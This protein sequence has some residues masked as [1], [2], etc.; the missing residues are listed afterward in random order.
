M[1]KLT[2]AGVAIAALLTAH[3]ANQR[4][5]AM[6]QERSGDH[7]LYLP[8]GRLL[9]VASLGYHAP[10]ADLIFLWS[11]QYY[12]HYHGSVRYDY[13][14]QIYE[15]VI[16]VLDPRFRD[17]YLLG[18][19]ILTL[20]ARRPEDGLALLDRGIEN[21]PDD[22]VLPFE[23]GFTA[24][25]SLKDYDR[26][27]AYFSRAVEIP[28]VHPVVRR[29]HA[30]MYQRMGDP[31]ASLTLWSD[32]LQS[33]G[34]D[35]VRNVAERHVKELVIEIHV[36]DLQTGVDLFRSR[37]GE[38]PPDLRTLVRAGILL[39]VPLDLDGRTYGYDPATGEVSSPEEG[40]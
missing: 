4:L 28:G 35:Y 34:S 1:R 24:F 31:R 37:A 13:V 38:L 11:I 39:E 23:A 33:A 16:T 30:D 8:S 19:L 10:L 21:N 32:L 17:A 15:R 36:E 9:R 3:A 20:E 5:E 2:V 6:V 12:G 22:W 7:L 27:A 25:H 29:F 14:R 40:P 18:S 26:A